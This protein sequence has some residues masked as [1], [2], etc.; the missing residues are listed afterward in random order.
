VAATDGAFSPGQGQPIIFSGVITNTGDE[1]LNNITC[2][3]DPVTDLTGVPAS[4][5]PG[6][7][8]TIT[9]SY[10]PDPAATGPFTDALTCSGTGAISGTAFAQSQ[11]HV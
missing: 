1:E 5:A 2:A 3:D 7:S 9:G 8:A 6:A 10:V 11:R 4:L